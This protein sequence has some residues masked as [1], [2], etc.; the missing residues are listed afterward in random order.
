MP[1]KPLASVARSG[2]ELGESG[3][4]FFKSPIIPIAI[5]GKVFKTSGKEMIRNQ[6][7]TG[8]MIHQDA[9]EGELR[10]PET[11][12]HRWFFGIQDKFSQI[13]PDAEPGEDAIA[14]PAPWDNAFTGH[15]RAQMPVMFLGIFFNAGVEP[16]II[17]AQ[18][19]KD[20]RSF[21]WHR[22]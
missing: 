6:L 12:I 11:E 7:S 16:V 18:G 2:D 10:P 14:F 15:I 20:S 21:G 4:S 17:P 19:Q 8:M 13:I 9:G 3:A 5:E 22:L 1:S